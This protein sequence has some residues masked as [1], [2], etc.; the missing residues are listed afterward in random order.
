MKQI[1]HGIEEAANLAYTSKLMEDTNLKDVSM[2][3]VVSQL[4]TEGYNI[5]SKQSSEGSITGIKLDSNSLS[6]SKEGTASINVT[7]EGKEEGMEYYA[8]VKGKYYLMTKTDKKIKLSREATDVSGSGIEK[9]EAKSENET[10]VQVEEIS[11]NTI[12]LKA[13]NT[14]GTTTITVTYGSFTETCTVSVVTT[15]TEGSEENTEISFATDYGT[16]DII[17]L[18]EDNTISSTPNEPVLES[19]GEK[20]TP[21]TWTYDESSKTWKE[22]ETTNSNWYNYNGTGKRGTDGKLEDNRQSQWANAKTANGSYFVWIPRYAYRITYYSSETETEPTGYYDGWGMWKNDGT[23]K[24]KIDE[25]IETVEYKGNKYI[26]HPAFCDGRE[27]EYANGEWDSELPGFWFAKYEMSGSSDLKSEPNLIC[28]REMSIGDQYV[29]AR[30]AKYGYTGTET[31]ITSGGT[32]YTHTN[33]MDSHLVK[34]SEWGA[35]AYL[36]QSKYGR[37]GNE[38]DINNNSLF[39]TGQGGDLASTT[40]NIYGIYDMSG[41]T[42]ERA[43]GYNKLSSSYLTS[44]TQGLNMT[45]EAKDADGNY[46]STKYVTAYE[47]ETNSSVNNAYNVCKIGDAIKEVRTGNDTSKAWFSDK[48]FL[49]N[50][51]SP[52]FERGGIYDS[53]A[54]AGVFC[55]NNSYGNSNSHYS[56]RTVLCP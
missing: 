6:I 20:M 44:S 49:V 13:G 10:Y 11:G 1:Y 17:W 39:R 55:S 8:V 16:I 28:L 29:K 42:W 7:Y 15:P 12:K 23:L 33:F 30:E 50:L 36:T 27:N 19:N 54:D 48:S 51:R 3:E 5:Y 35:V 46:T 26:V 31:K 24:Y 32:E 25:A 14:I 56:F 52:F 9:L 37:N 43:A 2:A 40:G 21:V 47:N 41:G 53:G 45:Q 22:D 38:I 34:N 4:Q 18:N